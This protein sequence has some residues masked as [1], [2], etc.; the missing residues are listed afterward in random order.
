MTFEKALDGGDSD[1]TNM[2]HMKPIS[3]RPRP[4]LATGRR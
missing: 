1:T 3:P 2:F 4:T